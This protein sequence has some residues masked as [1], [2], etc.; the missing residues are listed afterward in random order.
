MIELFQRIW[1]LTWRGQI[2]LIVLSL[3]VAALAAVPLQFQKSIING[4]DSSM[5]RERLFTLCAGYLGILILISSLR[6]A[7]NY[8]S[9]VLGENVIRRIRVRIY[10]DRL[11]FAQSDERD[12]RGQLVTMIANEA[13]ELGRFAGQAIASPMLQFG[14]LLSVVSFIA[15]TQPYLGL[16]LLMVILPQAL[17]VL[18]LQ[19]SINERLKTRVR[20]LRR[21]TA[22]IT[23]E[24]LEKAQQ[25][26]LDDF[27]EIFESRRKIFQLKLS[28]K[29]VLNIILGIGTVGI[30]LLGGLLLLD[31]RTDIGS[32][33]AA[34]TALTRINEP[35]R[36]LIAYYREL[37]A[38]RIR[39]ELLVNV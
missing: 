38:V 27:D 2:W 34:L 15:F 37:S 26:V 7:L 1:S 28:M 18:F 29:L 19:K 21:A 5:D 14:T 6:F 39:Y 32:V 33:V 20:V 17:V 16:F 24:A 4:L 31:G 9:Q 23:A 30:I 22:S 35:W 13:E 25:A 8:R 36:T 11:R 10:E 3:L 12:M